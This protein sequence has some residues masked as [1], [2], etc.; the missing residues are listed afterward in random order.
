MVKSTITESK[1]DETATEKRTKKKNRD[2][3]NSKPRK[4]RLN[5][6]Q[7]DQKEEFLHDDDMMGTKQLQ[8]QVR[9]LQSNQIMK[10]RDF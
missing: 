6:Y 10:I 1:E 2:C 4:R 5:N 8:V 9:S 3:D 7:D